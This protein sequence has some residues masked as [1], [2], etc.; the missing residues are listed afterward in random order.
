[1]KPCSFVQLEKW[2]KDQEQKSQKN[3]KLFPIRKSHGSPFSVQSEGIKNIYEIV[4]SLE[5][6]QKEVT[7]GCLTIRLLLSTNKAG[8]AMLNGE[9]CPELPHLQTLG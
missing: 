4:H 6:E 9:E 1:M 7:P 2:G 3:R 8:S 5:K